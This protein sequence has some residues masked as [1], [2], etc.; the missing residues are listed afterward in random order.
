MARQ[1]VSAELAAT[2]NLPGLLGIN[3]DR[4]RV[5]VEL[6]LPQRKDHITESL[7]PGL[8][9]LVIGFLLR[10]RES[11]PAAK[12]DPLV[13]VTDDY[14][15]AWLRPEDLDHFLVGLAAFFKVGSLPRTSSPVARTRVGEP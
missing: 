12:A 11:S 2:H 13:A 9:A 15:C 7:I 6:D 8:E 3:Q 4:R 14:L 5:Q 10:L 1:D